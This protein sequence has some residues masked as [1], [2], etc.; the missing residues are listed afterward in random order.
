[1]TMAQEKSL[2]DRLVLFMRTRDEA[3]AKIE[4]LPRE[5]VAWSQL[6][7]MLS[8]QERALGDALYQAAANADRLGRLAG[9]LG[10]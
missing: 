2:A 6:E 7:L 3:R 9:E 5:G 4:A 10:K 8:D 1:M